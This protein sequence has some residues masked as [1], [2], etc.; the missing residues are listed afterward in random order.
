MTFIGLNIKC[1]CIKLVDPLVWGYT[2][3]EYWQSVY[4]VDIA[5]SP[6]RIISNHEQSIKGIII[7]R[8]W[9]AKKCE[10]CIAVAW[11]TLLNSPRPTQ[12]LNLP[13]SQLKLT[14]LLPALWTHQNQIGIAAKEVRLITFLW[15]ISS[16]EITRK[17]R[18]TWGKGE[19]RQ[20]SN[21]R[22]RTR[23]TDNG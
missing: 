23:V 8:E 15:R 10:R 6:P 11:L 13:H 18:W 16:A 17:L 3:Y 12:R 9:C 19:G 20:W 2:N 22:R 21:E 4:M 5:E 14:T 1:S 7:K